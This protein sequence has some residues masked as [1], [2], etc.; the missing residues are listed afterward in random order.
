MRLLSPEWLLLIPVL[1]VAGWFWRG[2]KLARPLRVLCLLVVTALLVQPQVRKQS[3]ALD[4]W[5]LVD[6]SESAGD[7]LGPRISEWET[8][9]EKSLARLTG[10]TLW[11]LQGRR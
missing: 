5:V 10:S 7:L 11:T 6:Q 4:L 1:A 8:I 3:D 9:L 2:L